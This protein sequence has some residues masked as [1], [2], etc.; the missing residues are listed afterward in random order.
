MIF[1]ER[2]L[3]LALDYILP[4]AHT[5]WPTMGLELARVVSQHSN[6]E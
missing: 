4:L 5:P 2:G 3:T 1:R 6:R